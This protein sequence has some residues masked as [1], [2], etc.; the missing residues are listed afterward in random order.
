MCYQTFKHLQ[1][2]TINASKTLN[3]RLN[4]TNYSESQKETDVKATEQ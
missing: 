4:L 1:L 2:K 3:Y